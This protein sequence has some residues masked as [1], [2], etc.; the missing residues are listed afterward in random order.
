MR[1]MHPSSFGLGVMACLLAGLLGLGAGALMARLVPD[2]G[3]AWAGL[4]MVPLWFALETGFE[5]VAGAA[6]LVSR[7]ARIAAT[8]VVLA[9][10]YLAW[11]GTRL[12]LP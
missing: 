5:A 8:V 1:P 2:G 4:A 3:P 7:P 6:G 12:L 11:F 10:F 9:G